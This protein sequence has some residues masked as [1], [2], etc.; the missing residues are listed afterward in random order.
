MV[1]G[2]GIRDAGE[3]RNVHLYM[4]FFFAAALVAALVVSAVL[5]MK[6]SIAESQPKPDPEIG[7]VTKSDA[8]WK[9][10]LSPDA[11]RVLRQKGTERAYSGKYHDNHTKGIYYCAGCG[12]ELFSS[13]TKFESGTG[14]PSFYKPVKPNRVV[15]VRDTSHG[16][17]R[18][19][20]V[21]ARCLGHLGHVFDDGPKPTGLRYCMNSVAL[22]FKKK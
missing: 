12:L 21:C 9:K 10:I 15:E 1:R 3:M 2:K 11:Y 13:D 17:D 4:K 16:M 20:V 7:R 5:G 8:E 14:W 19:E 18:V 22:D 6:P